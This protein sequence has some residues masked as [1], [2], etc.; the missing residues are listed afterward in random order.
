MWLLISFSSV[1]PDG[2]APDHKPC[3]APV[4]LGPMRMDA[5][6]CLILKS[7][8]AQPPLERRSTPDH[9]GCGQLWVG[10]SRSRSALATS[11]PRSGPGPHKPVAPIQPLAPDHG[12]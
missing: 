2:N 9:R 4:T 8:L 1:R 10:F 5:W 7:E 6:W 3:V 12:G 11:A